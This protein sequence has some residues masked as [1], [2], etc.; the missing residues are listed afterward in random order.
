MKTLK[1]TFALLFTSLLSF[2]QPRGTTYEDLYA[3]D[4]IMEI[5]PGELVFIGVDQDDLLIQQTEGGRRNESMPT[6][7]FYPTGDAIFQAKYTSRKMFN[8]DP[9]IEF[10]FYSPSE[11]TLVTD[12]RGKILDQYDGHLVGI[13]NSFNDNSRP[14]WAIL[15]VG[16]SATSFSLAG[17][18]PTYRPEPS[19]GKKADTVYIERTTR[20]TVVIEN[21]ITRVDTVYLKEVT[22]QVDTVYNE[23]RVYVEGNIDTVYQ[24]TQQVTSQIDTVYRFTTQRF[25]TSRLDTVY[26]YR[27]DSLYLLGSDYLADINRVTSVENQ[28][29]VRQLSNPYPNPASSTVSID[30]V[31][32]TPSDNMFLGIY[33]SQGHRVGQFPVKVSGT[34]TFDVSDWSSGVYVYMIWSPVGVSSTKKLVIE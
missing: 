23:T 28:L 32:A 13:H 20:D 26:V 25:E 7:S 19:P 6:A 22:S 4:T 18:T 3:I 27:V 8:L 1:I 14:A 2:A 30:Y 17:H 24:I 9:D 5:S 11:G 29:E 34:I 15:R 21:L 10:V 31:T 12:G 33:D 16:T